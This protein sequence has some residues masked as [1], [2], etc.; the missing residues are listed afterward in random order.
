MS[1]LDLLIAARASAFLR[2]LCLLRHW[3]NP[4]L[5]VGLLPK[6]YRATAIHLPPGTP[7]ARAGPSRFAARRVP[8]DSA[9]SRSE[10]RKKRWG[11]SKKQKPPLFETALLLLCF[12]G[13]LGRLFRLL[14]HCSSRRGPRSC[15]NWR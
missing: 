9:L 4:P 15:R 13:L 6:G 14:R 11:S 8:R 12:L 7:L 1:P 10:S 3:S 2:L 5:Q